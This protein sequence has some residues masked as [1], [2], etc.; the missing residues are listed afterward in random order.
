M[1]TSLLSICHNGLVVMLG[2]NSRQETTQ[3][4]HCASTRGGQ[5]LSNHTSC[6]PDQYWTLR[7]YVGAATT[8][9]RTHIQ[10]LPKFAPRVGARNNLSCFLLRV[11]AQ[12]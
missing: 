9:A 10:C 2:M 5:E 3:V 1:Y 11:G 6:G 12:Q 4:V 7:D 8:R